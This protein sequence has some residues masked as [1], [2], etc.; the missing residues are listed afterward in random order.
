M[1]E[2]TPGPRTQKASGV[3]SSYGF[4]LQAAGIGMF[5]RSR[6]HGHRTTAGLVSAT[7]QGFSQLRV[8]SSSTS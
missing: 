5:L 7:A 3:A 8:N 4:Q 1:A 6:T 2:L